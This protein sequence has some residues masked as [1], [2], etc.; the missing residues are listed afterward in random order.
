VQAFTRDEL[1]TLAA[2]S[3][4]ASFLPEPAKA[5]WISRIDTTE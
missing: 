5:A 2:N 1:R 3:I 4:C